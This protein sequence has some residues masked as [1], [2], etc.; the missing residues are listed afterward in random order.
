MADVL[1]NWLEFRAAIEADIPPASPFL[2]ELFAAG[3]SIGS[4]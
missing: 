3:W 4:Q 2:D 1:S